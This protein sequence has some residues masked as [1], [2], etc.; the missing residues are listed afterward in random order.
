MVGR[1]LPILS[2]IL[3]FYLVILIAGFKKSLEVLPAIIVSGGSFAFFQW[4]SANYLGPMLPDVL[5]GLA[6]I[7]SLMVLL[8]YWKP[9]TIWHFREEPPQTIA[10][11]L[12][13]T[14]AQVIRAW[15]PFIIMTLMVIAWGLEPVKGALNTLG[16]VKFGI[17]GLQ[18]A[19][20]K[21]DGSLLVIK[22]F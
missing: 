20:L 2:L 15:T 6:S 7:I 12:V 17:P 1:T 11:E 10:T 13:Y 16:H 9:K 21:P 19:I 3:P 8:K 4:F 14:R 18:D 5:A 22:P